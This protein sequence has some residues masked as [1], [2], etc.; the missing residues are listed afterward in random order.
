MKVVRSALLPY[1]AD[2]MYRIVADVEAYPDFLGWCKNAE[3][4][5]GSEQEVVARL[6]LS[7]SKLN[8]LFTTRNQNRAGESIKLELVEGPF[9]D[10]TGQ[11]SFQ[12]L[13]DDACKVSVEMNFHFDSSIARRTMN[14]VFKNVITAQLNAF[15]QRAVD[16]HGRGSEVSSDA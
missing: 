6:H 15:Q 12:A 2:K 8:I 14:G 4:V 16:L 7:Y 1:S 3:I 9:A 13:Q 10:L 11:W 5:S